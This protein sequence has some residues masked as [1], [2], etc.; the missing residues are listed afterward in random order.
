MD[1][2]L[3]T[4]LSYFNFVVLQINFHE[5]IKI[6]W[7]L[8]F[9]IGPLRRHEASVPCSIQLSHNYV[10]IKA[11]SRHVIGSTNLAYTEK[12][13]TYQFLSD[14]PFK[15][16]FYSF[17]YYFPTGHCFIHPPLIFASQSLVIS[18]QHIKL[19]ISLLRQGQW[20]LCIV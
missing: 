16:F 15:A 18:L 12:K 10:I 5:I 2:K 17:F 11:C 19:C 14:F 8:H 1:W 3:Q 9:N 6:G 4:V 13:S 7:L 20:T